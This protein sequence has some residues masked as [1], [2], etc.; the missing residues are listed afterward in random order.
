MSTSEP[1]QCKPPSRRLR[2]LAPYL[3]L[4]VA[5]LITAVCTVYVRQT[6]AARQ[7][8]RFAA[9]VDSVSRNILDRVETCIDILRGAVGL[10]A[11]SK[12]VS[13][14]EFQ[15]YCQ[16]LDIRKRY[17]G[18]IGIGYALRIPAE[19]KQTVEAEL[20]KAIPE[21]RIWPQS[22]NQEYCPVVYFDPIDPANR[23][24]LGFDVLSEP[25]RRDALWRACDTAGAAAS[26]KISLIQSFDEQQSRTGFAI[27]LPVYAG[28]IVPPTVQQR[29][30]SLVG[31]VWCPFRA[32]ELL[33]GIAGK[34][35]LIDLAVY[36]SEQT[37]SERLMYRSG[38][39]AAWE[40]ASHTA[41]VRLEIA[42]R[43]WT[44]AFASNASFD[45]EGGWKA[46][47]FT[48]IGG[49]MA[50][51]LLFV[52]AR[53]QVRARNQAE[54]AAEEL[55]RS[56]SA[57]RASESRFRRLV[58]S[59]MIGVVFGK[60]DGRLVNANQAFCQLIGR[61]LKEIRNGQVT[62]TQI[63][64]P[65]YLHTIP[66]V[67]QE[68]STNGICAPFE[69]EYIRPDGTRVPVLLGVA[70]LEGSQTDTVAFTIDLT[71]QKRQQQELSR[72]RDAAEAASRAKDR[73]LAVLSHELRT[74]L[75]PV[76]AITTAG[77]QDSSLPQSVREDY[78]L[79]RRNIELEA[80]LI[81]DLLDLSRITHGRLSLQARIVD[82]HEVLKSAIEVCFPDEVAMKGLQV[83]TELGATEHH[84]R[85]D[86]DRLQQMFWNLIKNAVKFT[87]AGGR[88]TVRTHNPPETGRILIEIAD[89][90]VGIDTNDLP[91]IF[92]AFEQ[93]EFSMKY[94]SGGLG[95]GLSIAKGLV[96]A[97][98][99][100]IAAHSAGPGKGATFFVTLATVSPPS[101]RA[102]SVPETAGVVPKKLVILLVEDHPDTA[103]ALVRLLDEAGHQ[104]HVASS[105]A[106]ALEVG[107]RMDIDLL[108]S[109]IRLPDGSGVELLR[110][111][112][113]RPGRKTFQAIAISGYAMEQDLAFAATAG[114]A[115][116][117]TKP[118][119][120]QKLHSAI[121]Q[122]AESLP[123][124]A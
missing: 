83:V 108:L 118:I 77:Q 19:R 51:G 30:E 61:S 85:G 99:G 117:L 91:R 25:S 90:G 123:G 95:L 36:D 12:Q 32:D 53:W 103:R 64:A 11:A 98:G 45:R 100:T 120:F 48:L 75:T 31:V 72:A 73:F 119:S 112:K 50:S 78:A 16:S 88:I 74:P 84:V 113:T 46:T 81:D 10:F 38:S 115:R 20:Q 102:A 57:L 15:K 96:E 26:G 71:Q 47:I 68:L 29:R 93:G 58:E 110:R 104:V 114:F 82:L 124:P 89:T 21:F 66:R 27:Y 18:I 44:V 8:I 106:E 97:H 49:L 52:V 1:S 80:R 4:L 13:H 121:Q 17:P 59:N 54:T 70:M 3:M 9:A 60:T 109:D 39:E 14:D 62:W 116:H 37:S 35:A 94:G 69:K 22:S 92:D 111:L 28:G 107:D 42:G 43:A 40:Q 33:K 86:P 41:V 7:R 56:E 55:R 5:L 87:P 6:I 65:E 34:D 23:A 105:M 101:P 76:L 67:V 2:G 122:V 63:T 24:M 79:I